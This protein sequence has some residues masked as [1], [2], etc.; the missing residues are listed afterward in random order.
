VHFIILSQIPHI[1]PYEVDSI[2]VYIRSIFRLT[3]TVFLGDSITD[4]FD[5]EGIDT[6]NTYYAP[7]GAVNTGVSGDRTTTVIDRINN[8]GIINGLNAYQAVLKI[9]TNDLSGGTD[10]ATIVNNI[11]TIINLVKEKN[12]GVRVILLGILPRGGAD[13]HQRARNVNAMLARLANDSDIFFLDMDEQF[14]NGLGVVKPELFWDDQLHLS[15][16]GYVIWAQTMNPL[17]DRVLNTP[18]DA[19]AGNK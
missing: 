1:S 15:P 11:V 2:K 5:S 3:I 10:E 16:Q 19:K 4:W 12:P 18:F 8:Q 14:S 7:L 9:G 6:W 17:F 13:I